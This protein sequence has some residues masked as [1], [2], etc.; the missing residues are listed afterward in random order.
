MVDDKTMMT[1]I[2]SL[3]PLVNVIQ[4]PQQQEDTFV[5]LLK[6]ARYLMKMRLLRKMI[7]T[8][9]VFQLIPFKESFYEK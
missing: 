5:A 1:S 3:H 8:M 9:K 4:T 7:T 2:M 6:R